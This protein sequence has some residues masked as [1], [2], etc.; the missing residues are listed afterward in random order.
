LRVLQVLAE[1]AITEP[2]HRH[3][4]LANLKNLRHKLGELAGKVDRAVDE[5]ERGE[6]RLKQEL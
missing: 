2:D 6:R 1:A 3:L 4:A 5:A